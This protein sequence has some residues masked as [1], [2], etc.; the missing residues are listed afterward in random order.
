MN[1]FPSPPNS[2]HLGTFSHQQQDHVMCGDCNK[3]L[4]L[5]WFCSD[6]HKKC[7]S[8]NRFLGQD[9]YC[10]RCWSF[11]SKNQ[12][13][14]HCLNTSDFSGLPT[15]SNSTGSTEPKLLTRPYTYNI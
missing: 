11:D 2:P 13:F 5:D 4:G 7:N 8:C 1:Y 12:Q 6:C 14:S 9:E 10:T 3:T 15:P